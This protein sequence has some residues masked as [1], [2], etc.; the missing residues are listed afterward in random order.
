MLVALATVLAISTRTPMGIA[1]MTSSS[2]AFYLEAYQAS[3]MITT[4]RSDSPSSLAKT[5][6]NL[7]NAVPE[8]IFL[9]STEPLYEIGRAEDDF[10]GPLIF[11][12][13]AVFLL[14]DLLAVA[15]YPFIVFCLW[16]FGI[17]RLF[18]RIEAG[19]GHFWADRVCKP[20]AEASS[21]AIPNVTRIW[22]WEVLYLL[23]SRLFSFLLVTSAYVW[24]VSWLSL[25]SMTMELPDTVSVGPLSLACELEFWIHDGSVGVTKRVVLDKR[26]PVVLGFRTARESQ[27]HHDR[28]L[29]EPSGLFKKR[30][31]TH[32][33][34]IVAIALLVGFLP[35]AAISMVRTRRIR[36]RVRRRL[37][38]RCGYDLRGS[39]SGV[40]SECGF[41]LVEKPA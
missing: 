3:A 21:S 19:R 1:M 24:C 27:T 8:G 36:S 10:H 16:R 29:R 20:R 37:C 22:I 23:S 35:A 6:E 25:S 18:R 7:R 15:A 34:P 41:P 32:Y 4:I 11:Y 5:V 40:C 33:Y 38:I 30:E 39:V 26:R 12:T 28:R 9:S 14:R 13:I 31:F 17:S 2:T